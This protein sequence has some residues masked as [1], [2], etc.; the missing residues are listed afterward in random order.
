MQWISELL[1]YIIN[2]LAGKPTFPNTKSIIFCLST[3]TP[4]KVAMGTT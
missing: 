1:N 2:L 3:H 4:S